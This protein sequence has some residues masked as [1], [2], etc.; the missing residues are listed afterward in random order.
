MNKI[1]KLNCFIESSKDSQ[2][3]EL[4]S[5][6]LSLFNKTVGDSISAF[7]ATECSLKLMNM[8]IFELYNIYKELES[9]NLKVIVKDKNI[10]I[11]NEEETRLLHPIDVQNY[12][13]QILKENIEHS[14]RCFV[15]PSGTEDVVRIY[16]EASSIEIAMD[17]AKL[18]SNK[19]L[20][21]NI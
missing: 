20:E 6:F 9:V 8:T 19:I 18:V 7:I 21:I 13:D 4:V 5:I 10:F 3:L 11:P 16:S 12:I 2:T 14:A 15:R 17:I 1:E